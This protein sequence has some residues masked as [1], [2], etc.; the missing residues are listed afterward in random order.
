METELGKSKVYSVS[1]NRNLTHFYFQKS[2]DRKCRILDIM[3]IYVSQ[4]VS[5]CFLSH[6]S[7]LTVRGISVTKR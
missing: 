7:T 2:Q 5:P 4:M 1:L 6:F 3:F